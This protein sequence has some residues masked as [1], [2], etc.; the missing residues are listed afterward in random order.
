MMGCGSKVVS[1]PFVQTP[2][3]KSIKKETVF[4]ETEL[5][6]YFARYVDICNDKGELE[7]TEFVLQPELSGFSLSSLMFLRESKGTEI[8]NFDAFVKILNIL[9]PKCPT[10]AKYQCKRGMLLLCCY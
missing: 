1:H 10:E 2:D 5:K 4:T 9:S 6:R 8:I 3:F 7:H